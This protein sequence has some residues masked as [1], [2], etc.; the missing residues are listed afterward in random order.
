[1]AANATEQS[2]K[3]LSQAD[4]KQVGTV[5]FSGRPGPGRSGLSGLAEH[6]GHDQRS[7]ERGGERSG[8][9]SGQGDAQGESAV[10]LTKRR[11]KTAPD[12][13]LNKPPRDLPNTYWT[14][15]GGGWILEF[16]KKVKREWLYEYYGMLKLETLNVH[17]ANACRLRLRL[18]FVRLVGLLVVGLV[19]HCVGSTTLALE[20]IACSSLTAALRR[21][22]GSTLSPAFA[23]NHR[24]LASKL[25][26]SAILSLSAIST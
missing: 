9:R 22:S 18:V 8:E 17:L 2:N 14:R 24:F 4:R 26:S 23:P 15:K 21:L 10:S 1:V 11:R 6:S 7:C 20:R 5:E 25:I 12:G 19:G 13:D 3:G 16:K